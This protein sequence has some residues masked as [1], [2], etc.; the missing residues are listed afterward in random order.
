MSITIPNFTTSAVING[1]TLI[2]QA[3]EQLNILMTDVE[4]YVEST[5]QTV[6]T[7]LE[8]T[9]GIHVT[10][11]SNFAAQAEDS[12]TNA[13]LLYDMLTDI[14]L[15]VKASD[16]K[17][18]N[19]GNA[20]QLGALYFNSVSN[21]L[22]VYN[23]S[24]WD[25]I[26]TVDAYSKTEVQ[27]VLPRVGFDT[28]NVTS[29][30]VGQVAWNINENTLDVGLNGASLLLGQEQL[31]RVTN[32]S[33]VA[34][35]NGTAVMA[36]GTLGNSG[37][38]T[39]A[40]ANLTQTNAKYIL[41]I[42]TETIVNGA[43]GFVTAFGKVRGIQ[44]NG[45]NY[46]EAW[47]DGDVLYV[48][49]SGNGALTKVVPTN[50]QVKL[51][52]AIVVNSHVTNGTLFVRV[53]SIDENHAKAELA[54]KANINSPTLVTPNIG[55]ATGTS[56]NSI[57]GLA[58]VAP[59]VAGTAAV[60]T[61]TL[62]ARQDHVHPVQ[63]SVSG[64]AGT[65]TTLQTAR[66]ISGV[67][68]N[69]S[70]NINIEDRLGTAIASA[71]TTTVGTVGLGDYIHITGTTTI[72][73]LGTAG[74]AGI[75]RTLIFDGALTLTHNATSL[76]CPG[77]ANIVTVAGTVIEVVAESTANWRVVSITHPSLSIAELGYLNGVTSDI[78]TQLNAKAALASPALT[79][80]P[81]APTAAVGTNTAQIATTAFVNA[82]I[83]TKINNS[84]KGVANGVATLDVNGKVTLTQIPDSVLG[85]LEYQG[86]WDFTILPTAT[87][88]GQYW[89]ASISG[90]G[91]VVG[92]WAVWNGVAFD[93]VD[94]TDAVASVAGRTGNV[95]LTKT[96]A[97]LANVDN[98]ADNVKNVL[99]ATKWTTARTLSLTGDVTGNVSFDGSAN[100]NITTTVADDSHNHV[101]SNVDGLQ[102]ALDSKADKVSKQ[103]LDSNSA[104]RVSGTTVSLYKGDGTFDSIT[105]QDTVYTLPTATSTVKGGI[106]IFSDTV[107]T[108]ASNTV[109]TTAGRT[110]G[111]Q[112]N[113]AGQ[114]VV[115]V[116]W[117]DTN[118]VYTHPNSGVTAGTYPKVTV[119][120]QGHITAGASL[121][122][123]DIPSLDASKITSGTIDPAR[124]PS[125]VDDV[126]EFANLAGFP[127]TGE[128]GKIYIALDTNKSYRWSGSTYVYITSGAVD[129]VA[130]KTGVVTLVKADVGL[131]NVDNTSDANKPIS[132][133]TQ[134]ALN[135]KVDTSTN[136]TIAGVKTFSSTISGSISG[137]AA[138]A[139]KLAT[140]RTING[141]SFDG[142][143]NIVAPTNLTVGTITTT[144][145]P[146][147]SSTGT[148]ASIP[149][150]TTALA[151]VMTAADK[152]KLDGIA[153]GG[154]TASEILT[155]LKTVDGS[156][157]GVDAD[158]LDGQEGAYYLNASNINTG[159]INDSYLPD[160]I[161]SDVTGN[162]A[163][164]TKLQTARTIGGVSFDG[165]ANINLPGVN[166]AGN[167]NTTGNAA[168]VTNGV[169]TNSS[170]A[171][172]T[173]PLRIVDNTL[174][175][176]K[177]DGTSDSVAVAAQKG[178]ATVYGGAK[179]S[180]SGTTLTITTT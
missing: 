18:D 171:L 155:L 151:G 158:L 71:A 57:T 68:F 61:S 116:P 32:N 6:A 75:R 17:L 84:E 98:T 119:D 102:A 82:E 76:I 43:D 74:A 134:N 173:D 107:Q 67:S 175:L 169:Y 129:S 58:S 123:S 55:V 156:G 81:V 60:G 53:N 88:K 101:I 72:T 83:A 132:T 30:S 9:V 62:T 179:F 124:L 28:T 143:A 59:L 165:T 100:V 111:I 14:Y 39:V 112:L 38:I 42:V 23:D 105:T 166:T 90:N 16:P 104:L 40:K 144:T 7:N 89:I 78:Q 4:N 85:Q 115:N 45:A 137:N 159:T 180:L 87:Q 70:A 133:A 31:I 146:I 138:T 130:G 63:T 110:Y 161:T 10:T 34:I 157:S 164:A 44:T 120:A 128:A 27:T 95:V 33:G 154:Q 52:I 150:A 153:T 77:A 170:Q 122:A 99:S 178:T 141:V 162:A 92:D 117:S 152:T 109:S 135:T 139:T 114:A 131:A 25:T 66:T 69:G 160:T 3:D 47:V 113:S 103:S 94:N 5:Y 80:T 126:L 136:Q 79:G 148:N 168:T 97:G 93:K 36:T 149:A 20:L 177:G 172:N 37:R 48:K 108:V 106:E 24:T 96:D 167:Q 147:E 86:V 41:G 1:N 54:L 145:V 13:A 46:G 91:Y 29:P 163:T 21:S 8:G 142:T 174:Y 73:S 64:N 50:T 176:Y 35:D 65:A 127:T 19:D 49:D 22:L 12:A 11:A 121:S 118:T 56:F 140:A 26:N 2:S 51:P 15:G 125:F